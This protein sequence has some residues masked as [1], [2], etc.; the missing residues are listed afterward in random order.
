MPSECAE[1]ERGLNDSFELLD[2]HHSADADFNESEVEV[3]CEILS[4]TF[5]LRM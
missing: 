5:L 3:R 4:N 2:A 1:S